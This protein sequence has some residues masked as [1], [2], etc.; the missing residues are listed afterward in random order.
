GGVRESKLRRLVEVAGLVKDPLATIGEGNVAVLKADT[1]FAQ[2][3]NDCP[4]PTINKGFTLVLDTGRAAGSYSA[5]ISGTGTLEIRT[6][7]A[8]GKGKGALVPNG[9]APNTLKGT[10]RVKSGRV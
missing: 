8:S 10:W 4:I 1:T 3:L 6:N 5:A 7:G 9:S 2:P